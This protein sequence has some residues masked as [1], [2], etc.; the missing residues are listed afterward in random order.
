MT[1]QGMTVQ[2]G[3]PVS[4]FGFGGWSSALVGLLLSLLATGAGQ[5]VTAEERSGL[6]QPPRTP[7]AREASGRWQAPSGGTGQGGPAEAEQVTPPRPTP[8]MPP[9]RPAPGAPGGGLFVTYVSPSDPEYRE[10]ATVLRES[11]GL[12]E[13][14]QTVNEVFIF[15]RLEVVFDLCGVD[16]AFYDS[17]SRRIILCYEMVAALVEGFREDETLS[18]D[19]VGEKV[20]ASLIWTFFHEL[21]HAAVDIFDLPIT[22][23]EED[24]VDRFATLILLS[25]PDDEE[26]DIAER[27]IG[28]W[29]LATAESLEDLDFADEHPVSEQRW[30]TMACLM[31]G[32]NPRR[33]EHLVGAAGLPAERAE[34]CPA[35]YDKLSRS[36]EKLMRPH[37]RE[38]RG[39]ADESG[40]P[41]RA[42]AAARPQ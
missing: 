19:E 36:W 35:E 22:G 7:S 8:G 6:W 17:S 9:P 25:G 28:A 10:L 41:A 34:G 14:I 5:L 42:A 18:D 26:F 23:N 33:Y 29:D 2:K 1:A 32:S 21:G 12:D 37:L 16:N 24:A 39:G 27:A 15:P 40:S 3:N 38:G 11:Q 20:I 30:H 13:I 31:V 4:L